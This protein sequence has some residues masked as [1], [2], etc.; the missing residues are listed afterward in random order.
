MTKSYFIINTAIANIYSDGDFN[1]PVATQALLGETC[2][3]LDTQE[4]WVQIRQW[5]NYIGWVNK[6]QGVFSNEPYAPTVRYLDLQGNIYNTNHTVTR[7]ITFGGQVKVDTQ[8]AILPDG[9][10]GSINGKVGDFNKKPTREN[11]LNTTF[12]FLG[13]P[14]I[15][16][17]KTPSGFDCSGLVQTAFLANGL[18]M[19]RDARAQINMEELHDINFGQVKPGDL[20]FFGKEAITHVGISTGGFGIIHSQGWVKQDS[21]NPDEDKANIELIENLQSIKSIDGLL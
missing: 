3:V 8:F 10:E 19:Q 21:L 9:S 1:S 20:I 14:Y 2:S 5:D 16:G 6:G 13:S 4:K 7:S 12:K 15:W 17:G 18:S 11:I